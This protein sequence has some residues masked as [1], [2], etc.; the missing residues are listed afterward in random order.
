MD[1]ELCDPS[2][3]HEEQGSFLYQLIRILRKPMME[4]FKKWEGRLKMQLSIIQLSP[5][6]SITQG[7]P[8]QEEL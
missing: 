5:F 4:K 8:Q 7:L 1:N 6:C 3:A 2:W